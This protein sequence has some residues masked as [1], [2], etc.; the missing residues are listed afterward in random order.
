MPRFE[1][2]REIIYPY[3]TYILR[4]RHLPTILGSLSFRGE[5]L[6]KKSKDALVNVSSSTKACIF[7]NDLDRTAGTHQSQQ[8]IPYPRALRTIRNSFKK[9]PGMPFI[10]GFQSLLICVGLLAFTAFSDDAFLISKITAAAYLIL[11]LGVVLQLF[12][13]LRSYRKE[14]SRITSKE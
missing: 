13:F 4:D 3:I 2:L 10:L 9:N 1:R 5:E 12:R 11:A 14:D 7:H 6:G 8:R